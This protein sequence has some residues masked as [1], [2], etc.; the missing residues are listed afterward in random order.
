MNPRRSEQEKCIRN[1]CK[2]I[3]R[4]GQGLWQK[5]EKR[6]IR[7]KALRLRDDLQVKKMPRAGAQTWEEQEILC[8]RS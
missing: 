1:L 3:R 5:D 6:S 2:N 7:K 4:P 8:G